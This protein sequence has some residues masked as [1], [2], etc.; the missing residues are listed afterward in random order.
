[1]I[2]IKDSEI[3][4]IQLFLSGVGQIVPLYGIALSSIN[5]D[6]N[7]KIDLFIYY[8]LYPKYRAIFL[9]VQNIK[10][11]KI[12]LLKLYIYSS[13]QDRTFPRQVGNEKIFLAL[14]K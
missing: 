10:I 4:M 12:G 13:F 1:M 5:I 6:K 3:F 2:L 8:S 14:L 7:V 9:N 11:R